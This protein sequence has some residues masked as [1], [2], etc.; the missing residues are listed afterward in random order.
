VEVNAEMCFRMPRFDRFFAYIHGSL[1]A[2]RNLSVQ[3]MTSQGSEVLCTE[4]SLFLQNYLCFFED[5][6]FSIY[7]YTYRI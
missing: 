3:T 2:L 4:C 1:S 7:T 5:G 6:L